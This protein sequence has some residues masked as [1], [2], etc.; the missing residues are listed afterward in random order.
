VEKNFRNE[1]VLTDAFDAKSIVETQ[2]LRD[3][4]SSSSDDVDDNNNNFNTKGNGKTKSSGA[5]SEE[6]AGQKAKT[7][8]EGK[9]PT[10]TPSSDYA[11]TRER[12]YLHPYSPYAASIWLTAAQFEA[13]MLG[14]MWNHSTAF[15][16]SP[17]GLGET[18]AS[19]LTWDPNFGGRPTHL[20]HLNLAVEHQFPIHGTKGRRAG[21]RRGRGPERYYDIVDDCFNGPT[22][23]GSLSKLSLNRVEKMLAT[24]PGQLL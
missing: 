3:D 7:Q 19:G 8:E 14:P 15:G 2:A 11:S 20:T 17:W 16:H 4:P 12:I 24:E 1:S 13:Y 18:A 22:A 9:L 23:C 5:S 6:R 10:K 21:G